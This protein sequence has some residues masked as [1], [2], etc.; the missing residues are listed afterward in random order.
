MPSLQIVRVEASFSKRIVD[1][2]MKQKSDRWQQVCAFR[3]ALMPSM[4]SMVEVIT[5]FLLMY[6][7]VHGTALRPYKNAS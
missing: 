1:E 4:K 6:D 7:I 3:L 5:S 2:T